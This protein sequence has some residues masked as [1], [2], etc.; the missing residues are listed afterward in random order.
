M[1]NELNNAELIFENEEL[2]HVCAMTTERNNLNLNEYIH[3]Y[4]FIYICICI[5]KKK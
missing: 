1:Y 5:C 2:K 4:L 3:K